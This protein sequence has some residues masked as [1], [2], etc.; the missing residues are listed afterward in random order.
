[1]KE[2][3]MPQWMEA[4]REHIFTNGEPVEDLVRDESPWQTNAPRAI[5]AATVKSQ[6]GLLTRLRRAG[7]LTE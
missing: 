4:F 2:W 3:E 6:V 5:I 7:R 1:M